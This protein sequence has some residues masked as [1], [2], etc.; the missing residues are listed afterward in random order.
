MADERFAGR[1]L[2]VSSPKLLPSLLQREG[3]GR[4]TCIDLF[5]REIH[6]WK[7]VDPELELDVADATRLPYPD[8]SFDHA[9]CISVIEHVEGDGDAAA[10]AE[11]WRV[12]RPGGVLHITTNVA[13]EAGD[14]LRD[15]AV[16]SETSATGR[17]QVFFE[18]RYT[19]DTLEQRLLRDD[20]EVAHREISREIDGRVE[21][22]FYRWAPWSYALGGALRVWCPDNFE[23]VPGTGEMRPGEHGI[24]YL[25][26]VKRG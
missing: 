21:A 13:A 1:C 22:R 3:S 17:E 4:W 14:V 5:E 9:I 6:A 15:E 25:K 7:A 11:L 16:Y 18:R 10:M 19:D 26:L 12:L 23:R 8:A 24:A 20:W 2:D